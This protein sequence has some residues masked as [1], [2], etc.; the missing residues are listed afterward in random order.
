MAGLTPDEARLVRKLATLL[1][2]A[3]SLDRS[4][5]Q[6]VRQTAGQAA[7]ARR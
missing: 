2:V 5:H 6:P 1:R 3:D 7:R 4:H